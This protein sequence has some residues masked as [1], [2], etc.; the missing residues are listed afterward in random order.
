MKQLITLIALMLLAQATWATD[1]KDVFNE[2]KD[3]PR[4]EYVSISPFLMKIG[5]CFIDEEEGPEMAL[6]KQVRSMKVLDLSDCSP[7]VKARFTRRMADLDDKG[8]ETLVRVND[9]GEK[10]NI[11]VKQKNDVIREMLIVCAGT[12]DCTLVFFKGKFKPEDIDRLVNDN[13]TRRD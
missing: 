9:E 11:L 4:A 12:D 8:Y 10:V 2:F 5:Q 13:T 1:I 3:T 6:A 7:E